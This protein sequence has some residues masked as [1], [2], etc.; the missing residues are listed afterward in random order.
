M[1]TGQLLITI[2]G[3]G[4]GG[5]AALAL[6]NGVIKWLNGSAG[7]ERAHNADLRTQRNEA[8]GD[9]ETERARASNEQ[10]RADMEARNRN[11]IA[12]YAAALRRDCMEHGMTPDEIRPW[13][14]IETAPTATPPGG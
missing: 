5:A 3:A 6:V 1:D 2:F 9:A 4:T 11:R 13:P 14:V 7:R 12:D 8:W 10:A